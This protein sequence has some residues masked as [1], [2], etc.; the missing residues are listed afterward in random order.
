LII[1]AGK[2]QKRLVKAATL[3]VRVPVQL[4]RDGDHLP[5]RADVDYGQPNMELGV[6]GCA[7]EADA[8]AGLQELIGH[9]LQHVATAK[10]I[11][12]MGGGGGYE[13][14]VHV[15]MPAPTGVNV[16]VGSPGQTN[17]Y[18]WDEPSSDIDAVLQMVLVHVGGHPTVIRP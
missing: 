7:V 3:T 15:L 18:W 4:T 9:T 11:I 5:W 10:P 2:R 6:M 1:V 8:K 14:H 12:V 17:S 16:F 13:S